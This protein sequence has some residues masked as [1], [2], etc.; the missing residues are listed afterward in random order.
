MSLVKITLYLKEPEFESKAYVFDKR[1]RLILGRA[2]DCDFRLP[3]DFWHS[4]VSRH[5]CLLEIDPPSVRAQDL[6]SRNGTF[7]NGDKIGQRPGAEPP[8]NLYPR[9]NPG[10]ELKDGD[11]LRMASSVVNIAISSGDKDSKL[12]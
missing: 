8:G 7:V 10:R 12:N 6:G 3:N 2:R 1:A 11:Q 5:H 4:D 9:G